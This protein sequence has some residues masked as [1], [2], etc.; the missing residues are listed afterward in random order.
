[1]FWT[2]LVIFAALSLF[3]GLIWGYG[4]TVLER[5]GRKL[6]LDEAI[7]YR[8]E[9]RDLEEHVFDTA[10]VRLRKR[11]RAKPSQ[12]LGS[13]GAPAILGFAFVGVV[14][15]FGVSL[16]TLWILLRFAGGN[17]E[18]GVSGTIKEF[19]GKIEF[20]AA[21]LLGA[22]LVIVGFFFFGMYLMTK[23]SKSGRR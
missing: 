15:C 10:E 1:M 12:V 17:V 6:A 5:H 22:F 21:G 19:G 13:L 3:V 20:A 11:H 16:L 9:L 23:L 14:G 7:V 18:A 2:V 4:S 8:S